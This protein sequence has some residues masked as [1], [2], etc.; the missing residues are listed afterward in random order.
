MAMFDENTATMGG[1]TITI[2]KPKTR[3]QKIEEWRKIHQAE[4]NQ[5][6]HDAQCT[7]TPTRA[8]A[9]I[10]EAFDNPPID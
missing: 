4:Y 2:E 10:L 3:Q 6:C 1:A 9:L 5:T 8:Q 7:C